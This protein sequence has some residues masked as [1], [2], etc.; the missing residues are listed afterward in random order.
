[1]EGNE[2]I[3]EISL[4]QKPSE[5]VPMI[6]LWLLTLLQILCESQRRGKKQVQKIIKIKHSRK[7]GINFRM[8]MNLENILKYPASSSIFYFYCSYPVP[9]FKSVCMILHDRQHNKQACLF[10]IWYI[11]LTTLLQRFPK[12]KPFFMLFFLK[13]Q[14]TFK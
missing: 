2:E 11:L 7:M 13:R 3:D 4:K 6:L 1:M 9:M 10:L 5:W 14:A 12:N 8:L